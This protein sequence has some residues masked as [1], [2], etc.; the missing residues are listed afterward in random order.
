M[1]L[2]F[3]GRLR[4]FGHE[5]IGRVVTSNIPELANREVVVLHQFGCG[6]WLG[7]DNLCIEPKYRS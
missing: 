2:C 3:S 1:V 6:T 4:Y 7:N 5:I